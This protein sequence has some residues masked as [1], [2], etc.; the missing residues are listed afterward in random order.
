MEKWEQNFE[1][2]REEK[3]LYRIEKVL[4][5]DRAGVYEWMGKI[6]DKHREDN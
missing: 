4:R 2:W 6:V 3:L 5:T 1:E